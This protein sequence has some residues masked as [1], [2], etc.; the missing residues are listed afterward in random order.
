[1][2]AFQRRRWFVA[3]AVITLLFA[4]VCLAGYKGPTLTAFADV[5]GLI[6]MLGAAAITLGNALRRPHQER[7][8]WASLTFGF[9]LWA[10]NQA[11]WTWWENILH[12]PV[13]DPFFFDIVL[14]FHAVPMIAAVA[15]RP[16]ILK[17]QWSGRLSSLNFLT[18]FG[19]WIFLYA[20]I[21]FPY[22]YIN[23]RSD[24]YN[25]YYDRLYGLENVLLL[26]VLALA[27]WTSS[28]GWRR[29]YL[30][31]LGAAALYTINS[32]LLDRAA[33]ANTYYSGS[34]YDIPLI[35]T[36]AWMGAA[37][38]SSRQWEMTAVEFHLGPRWKK[39]IPQLA[40]LAIL[41]LPVLGLWTLIADTSDSSARVFRIFAVLAAMVF[42]GA[43]VFLRQYLQD[44]ALMVLL[45]ES[46]QG[47]DSQKRL[48]SQLVQKEKLASLGTLVAG[49]AHEINL[50]LDAI[51]SHSEQLWARQRLTDEQNTLVR[52]IV[53][54][55]QRTRDLVVDLLSFA[56]Q[57]PGEK[58]LVDLNMLLQRTNQMIEPRYPGGKVRIELVVQPGLPRIRGNVNQLFQ[59]FVEITEN[60]MDALLESKGGLKSV[61]GVL[62]IIASQQGDEA[63]IQFSDSGPGIRDPERVFDPFY[64]TKPVGKGAGLGLSVVY[65]IVLDHGGDITCQNK[66]EGGALFV[67]RIPIAAETA[68][69][70]AATARA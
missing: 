1:M 58:A 44:Q 31:L 60:A 6:L 23:H 20:F 19:W 62:A 10:A 28:A 41:S 9:T 49:A 2:G 4:G 14:F 15:W 37:A 18:L 66:P 27:A 26:A 69:Q 30:H 40:M 3:A 48:Q 39:I 12:R 22:Q 5:A 59:V 29:L 70:A 55:T 46:R 16:D 53:H 42:L 50:P 63:V 13:P 8:F 35:A 56:Q 36:V 54:Q 64:T 52:K 38:L 51:V 65:G 61:G 68:L 57:S 67:V 24:I 7:S 43:F 11:A 17:K 47:Y 33:A 45:R 25:S 32:Q 34:L 21:V